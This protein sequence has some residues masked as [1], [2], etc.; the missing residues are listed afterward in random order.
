MSLGPLWFEE[1][2]EEEKVRDEVEGKRRRPGR[3]VVT[4][5]RMPWWAPQRYLTGE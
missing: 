4:R 2:W 5:K 3:L 1:E